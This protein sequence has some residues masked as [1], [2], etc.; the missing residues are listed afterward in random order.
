[1]GLVYHCRLSA[2]LQR[3]LP[4][5]SQF[6]PQHLMP[7]SA[8]PKSKQP[9]C[10]KC[11]RLGYGACI[12]YGIRALGAKSSAYWRARTT[13]YH[14]SFP[15]VYVSRALCTLNVSFTVSLAC[16]PRFLTRWCTALGNGTIRNR[17]R[18]WCIRC[19]SSWRGRPRG[20][21]VPLHRGPA[22]LLHV[23]S[24]V[25]AKSFIQ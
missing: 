2:V 5:H 14:H 12:Q 21:H 16:R 25:G 17:F 8:Y 10:P 3:T 20:A 1:V 15:L 23:V 22:S 6:P 18:L 7:H 11:I 4:S 19:P 13:N 9:A 24:R